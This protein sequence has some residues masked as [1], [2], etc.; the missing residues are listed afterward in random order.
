MYLYLFWNSDGLFLPS[1]TLASVSVIQIDSLNSD[2]SVNFG[3]DRS[4]QVRS[5]PHPEEHLFD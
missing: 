3:K 5:D 2:L 4:Q 1:G